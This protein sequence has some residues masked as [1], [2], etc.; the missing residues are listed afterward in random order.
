MKQSIL[1][2]SAMLCGVATLILPAT[3]AAAQSKPVLVVTLSGIDEILGDVG[4][5][6]QVAGSGPVG[7]M[8]AMMANQYVQGLDRTRPIAVVLT[9][10][11]DELNPLGMIPVTDLP[12]FL[13]GLSQ[14]LG[15]PQDAGNGVF[16]LATPVP[17]YVKE[18]GGWAF[19]GPSIESLSK[20]PADPMAEMG[21][22]NTKYDI[23][24]RAVIKNLPDMYKQMALAKINEGVAQQIENSGNQLGAE[25]AALQQN[26]VKA[27]V[28]QWETMINEIDEL[29]IGWL[30]DR[31]EERTYIDVST[32][33]VPGTKTAD[34]MAAL[35]DMQSDFAGFV[36]P[37]AAAT[38]HA[39]G[40]LAEADIEQFVAMINPLR[41]SAKK[42]IDEDDDLPNDEAKQAA[43]SLVDQLFTVLE[44]TVREGKADVGAA[45]ILENQTMTVLSGFR[46]ADGAKLEK[47]VKDLVKLAEQDPDFP[48]IK[49]N[50]ATEGDVNFHSM[51]IP[52]PNEEAA[53]DVFGEQIDLIVGI[54]PKA[55]Y[56]GFGEGCLSG[57][58]G[59]IR[60]SA[61]ATGAAAPMH[62]NLALGQI[63]RF[64]AGFEDN[65]MVA[66][67]AT[68]LEANKGRDNVVIT[69]KAIP[70]GAQYR[71]EVQD[72][73]L[74]A[75]GQATQGGGRVPVGA[76]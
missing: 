34:Q 58:R 10:N 66:A 12:R 75:L 14:Q 64:A 18:Q 29:T 48:G 54:G 28:R 60:T 24:I 51:E 40:E 13:D 67:V 63:M 36:M 27:Q 49:F 76:R 35:K 26:L 45:L 37:G 38:L 6:S 30:I 65:P 25:E 57:L 44:E 21:D 1:R 53:R 41:E 50:A 56:F 42:E 11:G 73:V 43:K 46:V 39:V 52:V 62:L 32:T 59:A 69:G 9:A 55:A 70:N 68:A 15:D 31:K 19:V 20:L 71:F 16:E 72:G 23:G 33:A 22:L 61:Q 47:S 4:Y 3:H 17:T 7:Q 2:V 5:L 8:A 74:K